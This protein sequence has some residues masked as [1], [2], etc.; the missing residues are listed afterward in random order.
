MKKDLYENYGDCNPLDYCGLWIRKTANNEYKFVRVQ[1]TSWYCKDEIPTYIL[2]NGYINTTND[3]IDRESVISF[4]GLDETIDSDS[5]E[6]AIAC[7]D[8]Y[9]S[10]EFSDGVEDYKT[11]SRRDARK[12]I[13]SY[14]IVIHRSAA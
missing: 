1:N 3:W 7:L 5:V 14:G 12:Y 8:Y 4:S 11:T 9:G 10:I 6:Y 13:N 2:C